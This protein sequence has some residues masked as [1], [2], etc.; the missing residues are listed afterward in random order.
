[1]T[2]NW[3]T[4]A[5]IAYGIA[6]V[7]FIGALFVVPRNRKPSAATAWL[8][9]IFLLPYLGFLIF[10]LIGSP[11]LS[12]RRRVQQRTINEYIA[13]RA[14]TLEQ[15]PALAPVFDLPLPARYEPFA[16]LNTNLGDLPVC[17]GN[18]VDLLPDYDG[19]IQAITDAVTGA[20]AFV[21]VEYFILAA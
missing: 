1:M 6:W 7:I 8:M 18:T 13:E 16:R 3:S 21:H 10:L 19:A 17:S 12:K 5:V 11:K 14:E 20:Q 2:W 15:V 4:I 9:L